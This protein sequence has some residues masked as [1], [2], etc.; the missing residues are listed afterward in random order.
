MDASARKHKESAAPSL[1][2][3]AILES[4]GL[5]AN[6]NQLELSEFRDSSAAN[7]QSNIQSLT[8]P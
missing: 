2:Y 6:A 7:K 4:P 8:S 5:E 3:G 1:V